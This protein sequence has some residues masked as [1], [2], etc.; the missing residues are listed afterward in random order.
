MSPG[1][2]GWDASHL[3]DEAAPSTESERGLNASRALP[4]A[5]PVYRLLI[6]VLCT[7]FCAIVCQDLCAC[8]T[9]FGLARVLEDN[10]SHISTRVLGTMGYLDPEYLD[11]GGWVGASNLEVDR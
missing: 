10:G 1:G 2:P 11:T 9:D 6:V 5:F 3:S 8:I 4:F 7:V